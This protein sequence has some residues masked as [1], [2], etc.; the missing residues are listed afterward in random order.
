MFHLERF[1]PNS[2]NFLPL[3]LAILLGSSKLPSM[4]KKELRRLRRVSRHW[5]KEE[6]KKYLKTLEKGT[7]ESLIHP[8]R[9]EKLKN[10]NIFL[11]EPHKSRYAPYIPL[12]R[13]ALKKL[14]LKQ[15][16]AIKLIF[17]EGLSYR[18]I[19]SKMNLTP[20]AIV[21][22][23]TLAIQRLRKEFRAYGVYASPYIVGISKNSSSPFLNHSP[24]VHFQSQVKTPILTSNSKR[25]PSLNK[26]EEFYCRSLKKGA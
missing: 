4:T 24:K 18:S 3:G 1:L 16:E 13:R 22:E 17:W 12:L 6:W 14:T 21:K 11:W 25:I 2:G 15:R 5:S 20:S 19:A 8:K 9:Y 10:R 23:K 7:S 26:R